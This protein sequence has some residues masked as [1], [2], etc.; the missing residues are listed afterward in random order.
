MLSKQ[1]RE[2]IRQR[3]KV[4]VTLQKPATLAIRDKL[5]SL[6]IFHHS[7]HIAIYFAV[8]GEVA[9]APIIETI[10]AQNK[11]AY[12]PIVTVNNL[13][14]FV[15]YKKNDKLTTNQYRI[16]EPIPSPQRNITPQDLDLVIVPLVGFDQN[17]NRLGSGAGF[18]DR[19]FAFRKNCPKPPLIGIAYE[20]QKT[21]LQPEIWDVTLDYI[22]TEKNIYVSSSISSRSAILR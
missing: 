5:L 12:L 14:N 9:T 4:S 6:P 22:I 11:N 8:R 19:T 18:Y 21:N 16:P 17:C 13:L 3:Q 2:I 7:R 10:W 15:L 1:R 20:L